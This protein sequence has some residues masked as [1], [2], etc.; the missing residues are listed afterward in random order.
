MFRVL[1]PA[2]PFSIPP[3]GQPLAQNGVR[4]CGF[5]PRPPLLKPHQVHRVK[6]NLASFLCIGFPVNK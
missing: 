1:H 5:E 4:M 3:H 2:S 6:A